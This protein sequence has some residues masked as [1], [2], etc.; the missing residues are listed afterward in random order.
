MPLRNGGWSG[1]RHKRTLFHISAQGCS[2]LLAALCFLT[3][4]LLGQCMNE[5]M[6]EAASRMAGCLR[7]PGELHSPG[8]RIHSMPHEHNTR[9]LA[10]GPAP[11]STQRVLVR[12]VL[13]PTT[14]NRVLAWQPVPCYNQRSSQPGTPRR[15]RPRSRSAC[16]CR[17]L[18][19]AR[20]STPANGSRRIRACEKWG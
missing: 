9:A 12:V 20:R 6:T 2:F 5:R 11:R 7:P 3:L 8:H 14:C 15:W 18:P 10:R 17:L 1:E 16:L 19:T 4:K 13:A